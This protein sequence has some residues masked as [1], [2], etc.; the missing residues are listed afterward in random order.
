MTFDLPDVVQRLDG[1]APMRSVGRVTGVVGPAIQA[2]LDLARIGDQTEIDL[3][4]RRLPAEV[5]GFRRGEVVLMPL[6]ETRGVGPGCQVTATGTP[7][8]ISAGEALLGRVLD[9]LGRPIDGRPLPGGLEQWPVVRPAPNPL[10]R[11]R[12]ERQLVTGI[13]AIDGLNTLGEGQRLGLFAGPGAG[14][15]PTRHGYP[16]SVFSELPRLLERA[17]PRER[18]SI[19]AVYAVLVAGGD[20]EEPIADEVRGLL[21]GHLVLDPRLAGRGWWP[22][23]DVLAS[24]SRLMPVLAADRLGAA[25]R[26]RE[27]LDAWERVRDLVALG[28]YVAGKDPLA[29]LAVERMP[30][31]ERF[32]RQDSSER[33][34]VVETVARL[35]ALAA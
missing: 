18:G 27:L 26:V 3:D 6:G 4:G 23:V 28:A 24:L 2:L 5:V 31:I 13:R 12:I 7:A 15:P 21:D 8:A 9:G 16:P 35:Q 22:A 25:S 29:D 33:T 14:E 11:T 34:D 32:L 20:I 10:R 30:A 1:M 19:T 17:G